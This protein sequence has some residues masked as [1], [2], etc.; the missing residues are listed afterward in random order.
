LVVAAGTERGFSTM[1]DV[2]KA[3]RIRDPI[4]GYVSYTGIERIIIDSPIAQR[5]RHIGQSGMAQMVFPEVRS[6][7]FSHSLGAMHLG[8]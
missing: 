5:L 8:L 2:H 3:G 4:H 1:V 6:S 7:R